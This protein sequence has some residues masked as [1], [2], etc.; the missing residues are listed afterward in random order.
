LVLI[1]GLPANDAFYG[2]VQWNLVCWVYS[3][4]CFQLMGQ[5]RY[6]WCN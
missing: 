1:D 3:R 6:G 5:L 2:T 4:W